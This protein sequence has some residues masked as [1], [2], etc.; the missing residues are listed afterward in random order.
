MASLSM[1]HI[2][3]SRLIKTHAITSLLKHSQVIYVVVSIVIER[4]HAKEYEFKE[5]RFQIFN[6]T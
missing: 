3:D 1:N 2:Q 5:L 4:Y 6:E